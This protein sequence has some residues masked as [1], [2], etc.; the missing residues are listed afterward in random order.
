LSAIEP[1][2]ISTRRE[3][4]PAKVRGGVPERVVTASWRDREPP[5]AGPARSFSLDLARLRRERYLVPGS[6]GSA[7]AHEVNI[8]KRSLWRV[9]LDRGTEADGC[10]VVL[11]VASTKPSEGK[12][13]LSTNL[14]LSLLFADSRRVLLVDADTRRRD[15]SRILGVGESPGLGDWLGAQRATLDE[16][17]LRAERERLEIVPAGLPSAAGRDWTRQDCKQLV[18]ALRG[19]AAPDAVVVVDTPS[20][21]EAPTAHL[22]AEQADH[23]MF[24]VGAGRSRVDDIGFALAQFPD[25]ERLSFVLNRAVA[26]QSVASYVYGQRP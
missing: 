24:L 20:I 15:L 21:L 22:L 14:A 13:F 10:P 18:A 23:V 11:V 3:A 7:F 9:L 2:A 6:F 26:A 4:P 1:A 19:L 5:E 25:Q 16:Y 8:I 17:L 12:S